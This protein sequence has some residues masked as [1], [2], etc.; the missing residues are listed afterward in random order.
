LLG[1][2]FLFGFLQIAQLG[3][4]RITPEEVEKLLNLMNRTRVV[5]IKKQ[6]DDDPPL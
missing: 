5:Q 3:G 6:D 4:A 2:L 1:N